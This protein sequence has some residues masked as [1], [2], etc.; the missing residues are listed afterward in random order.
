MEILKHLGALGRNLP[1]LPE[2]D[3]KNIFI[4]IEFFK[5][6]GDDKDVDWNKLRDILI[7]LGK[8]RIDE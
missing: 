8:V 4:F 1:E 3:W 5:S 6:T 7:L 2:K